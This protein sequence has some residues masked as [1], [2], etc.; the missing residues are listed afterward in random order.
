MTKYDFTGKTV[1][2]TGGVGDI[3]RATAQRFLEA[4]AN[5]VVSDCNEKPEAVERLREISPNVMYVKCDIR[6]W[7][8]DEN[9]VAE[10]VRRFG[11]LDIL[12]NNAGINAQKPERKLFPDF[13]REFWDKVMDVNVN[14]TFYLSQIACRQMIAQGGEGGSI[15]NIAS[16]AGINP[17]KL[18]CAFPVAKAGVIMMARVMAMEL[19]P[20]NIRVNS[21]CPGS[22]LTEKT[23]AKF[24]ND[25]EKT[26]SLLS[27][28]PMKRPGNTDEIAHGILYLAS[29]EASYVTGS[30]LVIDGGWTCG[31][32]RDW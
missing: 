15:I 30:N 13:S 14:G 3:G 27:H 18:Q 6:V 9:L 22:I 7:E 16:V 4:G 17:L 29:D 21:L 10:T 5:V 1:I 24:Y 32:M 26:E 28:V 11:R 19:A 31:F 20:Y 12:V 8:E 2:I 23:Y 25:K